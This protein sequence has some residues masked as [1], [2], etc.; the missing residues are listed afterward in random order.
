MRSLVGQRA[1]KNGDRVR[2]AVVGH[3]DVGPDRID[4]LVLSHE[5]LAPLEQVDESVER[6]RR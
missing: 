5:A 6:A 4:E 1:A 2:Q 3:D